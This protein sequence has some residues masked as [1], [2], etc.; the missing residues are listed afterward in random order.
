MSNKFN[1]FQVITVSDTSFP[2]TPQSIF[3]I[4]YQ[5]SFSLL[6]K[7]STI[8]VEY[9]LDG[10]NLHGELVPNTPSAGIVFDNR[11]CSAVWFRVSS[12]SAQVRVEAWAG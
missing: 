2:G 4:K 5:T 6:N 3:G 11:A 8:T 10:I 7:S 1:Y 9:S 12:S